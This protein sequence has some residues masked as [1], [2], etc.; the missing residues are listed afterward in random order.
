MKSS[1]W[2]A[3]GAC[4][5]VSG[6]RPSPL[7]ASMQKHKTL[8]LFGHWSYVG[9]LGRKGCIRSA[10]G[11]KKREGLST[12]WQSHVPESDAGTWQSCHLACCDPSA[13][14]GF[15]WLLSVCHTCRKTGR[16]VHLSENERLICIEQAFTDRWMCPLAAVLWCFCEHTAY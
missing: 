5:C 4:V 10:E 16:T 7:S 15:L 2:K 14:Q 9:W 6:E 12:P 3:E 11:E 1:D 8:F 13:L